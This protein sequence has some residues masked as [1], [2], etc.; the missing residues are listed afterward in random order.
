VTTVSFEAWAEEGLLFRRRRE[1]ATWDLGDWLVRGGVLG[2]D[3]GFKHSMRITG[4]SRSYLYAL[5]TTATTWPAADRISA[6][7]WI[8][9]RHLCMEKDDLARRELLQVALAKRWTDR[10]AMAY[11]R[12]RPD[13]PASRARAY[14]NRR[15]RC[16]GCGH[17]FP[18]KGHK[19]IDALPPPSTSEPAIE[20]RPC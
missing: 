16:P 6:V 14:E 9:H 7:P 15:A 10:D 2:L 20:E 3:P 12:Q 11:F 13:A 18:I 17:V 19:D 5:H 1:G 8:V 4:Y